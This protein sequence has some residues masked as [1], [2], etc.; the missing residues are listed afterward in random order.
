VL[1]L[2]LCVFI[3]YLFFFYFK[4]YEVESVCFII[5]FL[6]VIVHTLTLY[7]LQIGLIQQAIPSYGSASNLSCS[8]SEPIQHGTATADSIQV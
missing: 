2:L 3:F 4:L 6:V 7:I 1:L 8:E 5:N